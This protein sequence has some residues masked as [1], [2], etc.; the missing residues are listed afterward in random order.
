MGIHNV[1][2]R[3]NLSGLLQWLTGNYCHTTRV[4]QG[5]QHIGI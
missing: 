1:F 2:V 4:N 3:Y 5:G